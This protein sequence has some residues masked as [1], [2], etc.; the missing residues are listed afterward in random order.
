MDAFSNVT[1]RVH[2]DPAVAALRCGHRFA[3]KLR[4]TTAQNDEVPVR[5]TLDGVTVW[6][7]ALAYN[8]PKNCSFTVYGLAAGDHLISCVNEG[9]TVGKSFMADYY[10]FQVLR[11][12]TGAVVIFR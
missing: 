4:Q 10:S 6:S 7:G 11:P 3:A 9:S 5:I 12:P 2:V 8:V 1:F